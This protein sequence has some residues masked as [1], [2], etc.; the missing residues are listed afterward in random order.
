MKF[1][2]CGMGSIGIR[3]ANN[4]QKTG[5]HTVIAFRSYNSKISI[6][7][8]TT[9]TF[10]SFDDALAENPDAALVTNPT[11]LHITTAIKIAETGIPIFIEK[12]LGHNLEHIEGLINICN[13]KNVP[14][15]IGYNIL[16]HP[17]YLKIKDLIHNKQIGNVIAS[18]VQFGTYMP[19]WHPW[20]DYTKS[21]AS[22]PEMG[23]GVVLTS[24][25]E[26]NYLIQ[27]FGKIDKFNAMAIG[28]GS[29]GIQ[30]EEGVEIIMKHKNAIVSNIHLNFFQKPN[31][32]NCQIIGTEGTLFW[33]F[34]KPEIQILKKG[35]TEIIHLGTSATQLLE[36]S[37]I[38]E[39]K[40][41]IDICKNKKTKPIADLNTGIYDVKMALEILE[42]IKTK[43]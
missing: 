33:D 10:N 22:L 36:E 42:E 30:V 21:Y 9:N 37:Y 19:D 35:K 40:H 34:W 1:L 18:K 28:T 15:L 31:Y 14:V 5:N 27:L 32:R 16:F 3:H 13:K 25:H 39:I 12:P 43:Q 29:L 8:N 11:N 7:N 20:E 26:F 17:A 41:F 38:N 6:E 23:G 4:I 2:I 24:I